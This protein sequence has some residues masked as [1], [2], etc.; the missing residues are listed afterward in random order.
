MK[1]HLSRKLFSILLSLM[2]VMSYSAFSF[3]DEGDSSTVNDSEAANSDAETS[4]DQGVDATTEDNAGETS[5]EDTNAEDNTEEN[6]TA[7]GNS[8]NATPEDGTTDANAEENAGA[9]TSTDGA[10]TGD[11]A[12]DS[13]ATDNATDETATDGS[14]QTGETGTETETEPEAEVGRSWIEGYFE[15]VSYEPTST[16]KSINDITDIVLKVTVDLV[17]EQVIE[18]GEGSDMTRERTEI[19][20]TTKVVEIPSGDWYEVRDNRGIL[21]HPTFNSEGYANSGAEGLESV[22]IRFVWTILADRYEFKKILE[23]KLGEDLSIYHR[24]VVSAQG[25]ENRFDSYDFTPDL[26]DMDSWG[27]QVLNFNIKLSDEAI[28]ESVKNVTSASNGAGNAAS[29]KTDVPA[30]GDTSDMVGFAII[31]LLSA[32]LMLTMRIRLKKN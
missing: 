14:E 31:G 32:M 18:T 25:A 9:E 30:T 21:I 23:S 3:A 10:A 29:S 22:D 6:D 17:K 5:T 16:T 13:T 24:G 8:E 26:T 2:L 20:R 11:S 15:I 12:A 1:S 7:D 19:E 28:G 27:G 4:E